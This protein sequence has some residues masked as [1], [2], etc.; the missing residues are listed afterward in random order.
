LKDLGITET[1]AKYMMAVSA[2]TPEQLERFINF[3]TRR[4]DYSR[5]DYARLRRFLRAEAKRSPHGRP[6]GPV[7]RGV[8]K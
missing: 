8:G 5:R 4:V 1:H 6:A 3:G 7:R 2:L